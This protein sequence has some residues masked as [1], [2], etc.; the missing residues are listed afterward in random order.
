M[1]KTVFAF[2]ALA[3]ALAGCTEPQKQQ[4]GYFEA[5]FQDPACTGRLCFDEIIALDDGFVF[6]KQSSDM[7]SYDASFC[8]ADMAKLNDA[9]SFLD[10][11]LK[12]S[13][14]VECQGCESFHIF[15]N[16]GKE[17][18]SRSV[19]VKE[20]EFEKE[21]YE[22]AKGLCAESMEAELVHFIY[23]KGKEFTD[24]HVFSNNKIVFEKFGLRDGELLDSSVKTITAEEFAEIKGLVPQEFFSTDSQDNCPANGYFY[25]YVE[26]VIGGKQAAA[27]SCG[28]ESPAGTTFDALKARL[29]G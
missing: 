13:R 14:F 21:A 11:R 22:K 20:Q 2:L 10:S 3:L 18:K 19:P 16:N 27:F 26:A 6:M 25:G 9:F 17:T 4:A 12:E 29:S 28:G 5:V 23:G 24:F 7:M 1:E 15:Y 8:S